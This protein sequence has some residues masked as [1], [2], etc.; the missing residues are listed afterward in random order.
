MRNTVYVRPPDKRSA[1]PKS[2]RAPKGPVRE[3]SGGLFRYRVQLAPALLAFFLGA[4][5]AIMEGLGDRIDPRLKWIIPIVLV[6]AAAWMWFLGIEKP[7]SQPDTK[8]KRTERLY[9][10][11]VIAVALAWNRLIT[12]DGV[13]SLTLKWYAVLALAT[14]PVAA[15]WLWHRRI[16]GSIAV[17]FDSRIPFKVRRQMEARARTVIHDWDSFTRASA[18]AGSNLLMVTFDM[19]SVVLRVRLGRA[20][21]A[22]DFTD[23]RKSRLES[24]FDARLGSARVMPVAGESARMVDIRFMLADPLKEAIIPTDEDITGD[25][26]MTMDIGVFETGA[27]VIIDIIHTLIAGASDAGKSGII[28]AIMRCLVRKTSISVLGID[29]KP[30]APELGKWESTMADLAKNEAEAEVMLRK[31]VFAIERRGEIMKLRKIR[32]WVPTPD[33]PFIVLIIDEVA[34]IKKAGPRLT[35]L[36]VKVSELSRAYGF[37]MI[38]ATQHPTDKSIP[39]EAAANCLQRIG[40]ECKASTAERLIFGDDATKDGWRLSP[41]HMKAQGMFRVQSRR[42]GTP[43]LARAYWM[44]DNTVDYEAERY[45]PMRVPIDSGTWNAVA[46]GTHR[47]A[48]EPEEEPDDGTTVAVIVED[49]PEEGVFMAVCGG[50]GTPKAISE[51]LGG[52]PLRTVNDHLRNLARKNMIKLQMPKMRASARN[53]WRRA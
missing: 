26:E 24:A 42:Y 19:V 29:M 9:G 5:T 2:G 11:A 43:N 10:L 7:L 14:Y 6:G 25:D 49:S 21:V 4:W 16:R 39:T 12:F 41:R 51:Y 38:M 18:A 44:D 46:P 35:R 27:K 37:A 45:A 22:Q 32:K 3:V 33:E 52:M 53:P 36:L 31:I 17:H 28:N 13:V 50:V 15:P 48:I 47:R 1:G 34:Q 23:L 8:R 40:L 20:R 30:G